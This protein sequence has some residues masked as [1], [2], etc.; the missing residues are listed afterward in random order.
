VRF[1]FGTFG[2]EVELHSLV[3]LVR[4]VTGFNVM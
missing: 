3:K 4:W 2:C 1:E